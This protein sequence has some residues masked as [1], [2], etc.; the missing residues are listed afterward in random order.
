MLVPIK[1][2]RKTD[3]M[4]LTFLRN[5]LA[6]A[7]LG[8][9][10]IIIRKAGA[11]GRARKYGVEKMVSRS[12]MVKIS[13]KIYCVVIVKSL[14]LWLMFSKEL[15]RKATSILASMMLPKNENIVM[16]KVKM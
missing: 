16:T 8:V 13:M 15:V 1:A 9:F 14:A 12:F 7:R 10:A 2:G 11:A 3:T 4:W 5:S 6:L